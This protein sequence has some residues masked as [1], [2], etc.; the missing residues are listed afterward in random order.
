MKLGVWHGAIVGTPATD[1]KTF[2]TYAGQYVQFIK[3]NDIE[4]AFFILMDPGITAG[5]YVKNGWLEKY[6]LNELPT[7]CQAGL[8]LDTEPCSPWKNSK[9]IF[10]SGDTMELA[11]KYISNL[12]LTAKNKIT[13]VAFDYE[14]VTSYYSKPGMAWIESLWWK[15]LPSI[16]MDYGFAPPGTNDQG[17]HSYPEVYWVGE[18]SACG[19]TGN[20]GLNCQC[21]N[22]PY[23]KNNGNPDGLLSGK[24]GDYLNNHKTWLSQTNVWPMFSV[25]NLSKP[26]CVA[27]PYSKQNICGVM[28]AFGNWTKKDFLKFLDEVEVKYGI[29]QSMIY[30]WQYIPKSWL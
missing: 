21:P 5:T 15:Y 22:T 25:E 3:D 13:C 18:M 29:K 17:H 1:E 30:E 27:S 16:T 14:D 28:D 10:D 2:A 6:W 23:C 7:N 9:R 19:C 20:K 12:N 24:I 11:F 4:R 26:N 8:V